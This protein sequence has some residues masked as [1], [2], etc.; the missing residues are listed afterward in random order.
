VIHDVSNKGNMIE[1]GN[2]DTSPSFVGDGFNGCWG[3][4]PWLPSGNIIA[5]DIEKGLYVLGATYERGCYL[6]GNITDAS[7]TTP[8]NNASVEIIGVNIF[9]QSSLVGDY[10]TG[11]AVSGTYD[12]VYSHPQYF[13]DTAFAVTLSNGVVT[14]K[15]MQLVP[16][17]GFTLTVHANDLN[18]SSGIV[19]TEVYIYNND[20]TFN[21][22]TDVNGDVEFTNFY[23]G[24]YNIH[25]GLWGYVE[26]CSTGELIDGS[27][28]NYIADLQ[29]GYSDL[30]NLDLGWTVS[31]NAPDGVWERAVPDGTTFQGDQCNPGEDAT[32]CGDMAYVTGNAGGNAG[33][34]DVDQSATILESPVI[35]LNPALGGAA[36]VSME[37]WWFNAGGNNSPNDTLSL[38]LIDGSQQELIAEFLPA[39][40]GIQWDSFSTYVPLNLDWNN[41]Q[42]KLITADW[43]ADGGNLV[44]AGI[45]NFSIYE[46]ISISNTAYS[47]IDIYPN[48]SN[49]EFYINS[50]L[51]IDSYQVYDLAGK[52]VQNSTVI[53]NV[54]QVKD[55]GVYFVVF[56]VN[57]LETKPKKI[58]V[59]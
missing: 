9:D 36:I 39:Q 57:G 37:L 26:Y 20:F 23:P 55:K 58:I 7:N 8:I 49:G 48:P 3:V 2:F 19:N 54:F 15:D 59:Y 24:T 28:L 46:T 42:L 40:S 25:V 17:Q 38:Y 5:S 56:Q 22:Q 30:F 13:S 31:G 47:A 1:V 10:A 35:T 41:L 29:Q 50:D 4:F 18:T 32:D 51:D 33:S 44:E 16:I 14:V 45:D 52:L 53:S 34:D 21:G 11:Y 12:V 43:Q 6:E 27:N